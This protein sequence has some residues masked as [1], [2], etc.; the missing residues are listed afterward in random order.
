M[1]IL[2][3]AYFHFANTAKLMIKLMEEKQASQWT[4]KVKAAFLTLKEVLCT[5]NSCIPTDKREVCQWN[6]YIHTYA[7]HR[8]LS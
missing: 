8:S 7:F 1:H 4:Q 3:T 2:Q 6:T 5:E